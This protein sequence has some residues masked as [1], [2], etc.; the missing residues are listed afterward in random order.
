VSDAAGGDR[1]LQTGN[2]VAGNLKI[3]QAM[4]SRIR[5]FLSSSLRA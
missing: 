2:V 5:P 4:L 1:H 3:Q